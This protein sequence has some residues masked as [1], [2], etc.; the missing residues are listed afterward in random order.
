VVISSHNI[1]LIYEVYGARSV[2]PNGEVLTSGALACR[3]LPAQ[4]RR[5]KLYSEP[6]WPLCKSENLF[7]CMR[8]KQV[9]EAL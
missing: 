3:T 7:A 9:K 5:K 2:L 1:D 6:G 8:A 4:G